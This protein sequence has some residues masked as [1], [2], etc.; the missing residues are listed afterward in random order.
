MNTKGKYIAILGVLLQF[1]FVIGPIVTINAMIR[2]FNEISAGGGTPRAEALAACINSA[3]DATAIGLFFFLIG[4]I[5]ILISLFGM[6]Y[7]DD[8]LYTTLWFLSVLWLLS[9]PI[10]TILGIAMMIYLGT[11]KAEFGCGQQVQPHAD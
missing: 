1:G 8:W 3:F 4:V 6:K 5:L 2:T 7:R 11:H 10:G 9:I